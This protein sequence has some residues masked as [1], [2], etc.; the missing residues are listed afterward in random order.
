MEIGIPCWIGHG[1]QTYIYIPYIMDHRDCEIFPE[2]LTRLILH[3]GLLF[4]FYMRLRNI[5]SEQ[6]LGISVIWESKL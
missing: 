1:I 3:I 6:T 2:L 4:Y 5:R